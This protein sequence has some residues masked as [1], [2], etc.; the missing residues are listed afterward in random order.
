M[1][2]RVPIARLN[3]VDQAAAYDPII[4]AA[5]KAMSRGEAEPHQQQ[6]LLDWIIKEASGIGAQ[7]FRAGDPYATHFAD[8]RRFV[9]I[10]IVHLMTKEVTRG[11]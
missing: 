5:L 2:K 6:V 10:Q 3:P 11:D 8:G 1:T 7:S 9:G 4:P